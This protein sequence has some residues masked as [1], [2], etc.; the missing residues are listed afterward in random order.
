MRHSRAGCRNLNSGSNQRAIV[1]RL[2]EDR[3]VVS[4]RE[5]ARA[6]QKSTSSRNGRKHTEF[7]GAAFFEDL[8]KRGS[9]L[10][11]S[12]GGGEKGR[13]YLVALAA[14][15]DLVVDVG[16]GFFR[17]VHALSGN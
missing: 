14:R 12:W 10:E 16:E 5:D 9:E 6:A 15:V 17:G 8:E 7:K 1:S 4:T 13:K 3:M 2:A 11:G